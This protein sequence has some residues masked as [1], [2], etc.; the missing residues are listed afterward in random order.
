MEK[1]KRSLGSFVVPLLSIILAFVIGGIIMAALG[2][3]P[4]DAVKYLF[5]G[6]FGSK[7]NIG[8]TLTKATPLMFTKK[9]NLALFF[10]DIA[11]PKERKH[12]SQNNQRNSICRYRGHEIIDDIKAEKCSDSI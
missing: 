9:V 6:A 3:N 5:Q 2:A 10:L 1:L 4:F 11:N 7:A 8:T 12:Q